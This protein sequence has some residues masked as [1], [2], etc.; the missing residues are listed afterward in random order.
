MTYAIQIKRDD[1]EVIR[2]LMEEFFSRHELSNE[3]TAALHNLCREL[4]VGR[5]VPEHGSGP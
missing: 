4:G 2:K 3:E 1:A 5:P